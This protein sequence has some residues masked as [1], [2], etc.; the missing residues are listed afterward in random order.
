MSDIQT[1]D[2]IPKPYPSCP[3]CGGETFLAQ[4]H[5]AVEKVMDVFRCRSCDVEYPVVRKGEA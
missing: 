3:L 5:K 2:L 1:G 4:M